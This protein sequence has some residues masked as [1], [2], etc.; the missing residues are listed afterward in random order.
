MHI[1]LVVQLFV[2]LFLIPEL[3][4][5]ALGDLYQNIEKEVKNKLEKSTKATEMFQNDLA[6]AKIAKNVV[7]NMK[8]K[9]PSKD[10]VLPSTVESTGN[11]TLISRKKCFVFIFWKFFFQMVISTK[12]YRSKM[13]KSGI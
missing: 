8:L 12:P 3:K 4:S 7:T 13:K 11:C 6:F 2:Y 10:V 1:I 9:L 5:N